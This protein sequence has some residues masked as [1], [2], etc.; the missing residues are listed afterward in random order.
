MGSNRVAAHEVTGANFWK[1]KA[2]ANLEVWNSLLKK[3]QKKS[4]WK[5]QNKDITI[6]TV[7]VFNTMG[8]TQE[9]AGKYSPFFL[10]N[11][12]SLSPLKIAA[13]E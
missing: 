5:V 4:P 6:S 1:T 11:A 9:T 2:M 10:T 13:F 7:V 8:R 12:F 3:S